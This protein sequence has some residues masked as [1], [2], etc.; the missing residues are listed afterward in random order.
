MNMEPVP[1]LK[2]MEEGTNMMMR[3]RLRA[4]ASRRRGIGST[5]KAKLRGGDI[6]ER[7]REKRERE[8]ERKRGHKPTVLIAI[9]SLSAGYKIFILVKS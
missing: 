3:Y 2:V 9:I 8:K 4:R 7:E 1:D 6:V 5:E